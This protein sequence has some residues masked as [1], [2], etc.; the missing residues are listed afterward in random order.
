VETRSKKLKTDNKTNEEQPQ[1][2]GVQ[3]TPILD[4]VSLGMSS[5]SRTA[6]QPIH[7][8]DI[9]L[10]DLR[11]ALQAE[12]NTAEFR[13]EGTLVINNTVAVRKSGTGRIEVEGM[14]TLGAM[15]RLD[16][17]FYATKRKVYDMLAVVSG[18]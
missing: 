13:G 3:L 12:N 1:Q 17:T 7:V 16:G 2:N 15:G 6:A 10:A 4:I 14:V 5:V 8:G 11:K 18:A 9:R